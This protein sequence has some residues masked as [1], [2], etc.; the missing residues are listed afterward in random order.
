MARGRTRLAIYSLWKRELVRFCRDRARVF[1]SLGQPILFWVLLGAALRNA[2]VA[3]AGEVLPASYGEYFFAGAL[4]MV[5]LFTSIFTTITV[6]ED[7]Q[8]GFLQGVLVAPVP[9]TAIALG[10]ISGGAT[11][12]V[13]QSLVFLVLAPA[14]GVP[15]TAAGAAQAAAALVLLSFALVGLGF[16]I[17]WRMDSTAAYHGIMMVFLLPLWLLSGAMF[18]VQGAH[19]ALAFAMNLNPMTYGLAAVRHG[20]YGPA[21]AQVRDLPAPA[22]AWAV[23]AAFAA[24][25]LALGTLAVHRRS[26]RDAA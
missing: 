4:T 19:P 13:A 2:Q 12:A 16:A 17:A 9:R 7:R 23:T 8:L 3:V 15:L 5:V 11:L 26:V 22:L 20:L 24:A 18:P 10:K 1:S 21:S 6:I 14:A 25:T